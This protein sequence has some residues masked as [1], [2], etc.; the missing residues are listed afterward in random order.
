MRRWIVGVIIIVGISIA[1]A[2][3]FSALAQSAYISISARPAYGSISVHGDERV[4]QITELDVHVDWHKAATS[5]L[6][7][8]D[9]IAGWKTTH[10][11]PDGYES[12]E[13]CD[14]D[15]VPEATRLGPG[16]VVWGTGNLWRGA[17]CNLR[18][19][20][21]PTVPGTYVIRAHFI[22]G[23]WPRLLNFRTMK[24]SETNLRLTVAP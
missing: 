15:N 2:S 11:G 14:E 6:V 23:T 5:T 13:F 3:L 21:I 8:L 7:R 4:G 17:S 1:S 10:F 16:S 19:F 22:A 18:L 12:R 20:L 24:G 9:D